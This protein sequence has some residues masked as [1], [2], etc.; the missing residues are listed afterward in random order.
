MIIDE[1]IANNQQ[2]P[3]I[4]FLKRAVNFKSTKF[5]LIT[6][7]K[8]RKHQEIEEIVKPKALTREQK[9]GAKFAW[10]RFTRGL[11]QVLGERLSYHIESTDTRERLYKMAY[12]IKFVN[13]DPPAA[14][15]SAATL[16]QIESTSFLNDNV[17]S[18]LVQ[19]ISRKHRNYKRQKRQNEMVSLYKDS[20]KLDEFRDR[21]ENNQF[22]SYVN[23]SPR[24]FQ[25]KGF[26]DSAETPMFPKLPAFKFP[27][28]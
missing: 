4:A 22:E 3:V 14:R 24:R 25:P 15:S 26:A 16:P 9:V 2:N 21:I 6:L 18:E 1:A 7:L 12:Y 8:E 5:M 27:A 13:P 28:N 17:P 11:L 23:N 19:H 10:K 20:S